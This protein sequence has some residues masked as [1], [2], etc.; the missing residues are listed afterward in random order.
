MIAISDFTTNKT[1][2]VETQDFSNNLSSVQ[3]S[4]SKSETSFIDFV[5]SY[6][7]SKNSNETQKTEN[8]QNTT[9]NQTETTGKTSK[10]ENTE[11]A[12]NDDKTSTVEKNSETKDEVKTE[13]SKIGEKSENLEDKK[14]S[15]TEEKSD[16]KNL[17]KV[18]DENKKNEK[19][20]LKSQKNLGKE[21]NQSKIEEK[22]LSRFENLT[23]TFVKNQTETQ[24][25]PKNKKNDDFTETKNVENLVEIEKNENLTLKK[26]NFEPKDFNF[27]ENKEKSQNKELKF[28]KEGKILVQDLRTQKSDE[29]EAK[30]EPKL[31]T[32]VKQTSEN[33]ATL[34]MNYASQD[35]NSD[36]LSLNNQTA[37][38]NGSNFQS[39]L[40]NQIQ[41]NIPEFVKA[42]NIVLKDN[43]QGSINLVLHPD[44][45]GNVKIHLTLDGKNLSGHISVTTKEALEVFK[46]NSETLR[47]AF[48]KNGFESANF[49][50]S[51]GNG[52]GANQNFN[53]EQ[54][55]DG[56]SYFAKQIYENDKN[57]F[58][59]EN[60]NLGEKVA[61]FENYSVNIVA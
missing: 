20:N 14:S 7:N 9:A 10:K 8:S 31:K 6:Q 55:N 15:K 54:K 35:A 21:E 38:S 12:K 36:I 43:N 2:S 3:N 13:N 52:G 58:S 27:G 23:S 26:D 48:I 59:N 19:I 1:N 32:T 18:K 5:N 60:A 16:E 47:E 33:T 46:D 41:Q 45:L 39:M 56:T 29:I 61:N 25:N 22:D 28:D 53:F 57:A 34:T 17:P 30:V 42:G 44:D 51:Y 50:V 4:F 24:E 40:N 37:S 49:D 11:I